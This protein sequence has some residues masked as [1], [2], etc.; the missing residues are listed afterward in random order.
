M[1][2]V[3]VIQARA[4]DVVEIQWIDADGTRTVER[5]TIAPKLVRER[6]HSFRVTE[7]DGKPSDSGDKS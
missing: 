7:G 4:G 1:P 2:T 5:H 3:K 6:R